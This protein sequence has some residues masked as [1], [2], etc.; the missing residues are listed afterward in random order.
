[1]LKLGV[2]RDTL[3][4]LLLVI[5]IYLQ[6]IRFIVI[7]DTCLVMH[8]TFRSSNEHRIHCRTCRGMSGC[9]QLSPC[10]WTRPDLLYG[11]LWQHLCCSGT[12]QHYFRR[13]TYTV[14]MITMLLHHIFYIK[15]CTNPQNNFQIFKM[16]LYN[17]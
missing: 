3:L 16:F 6:Y 15:L 9:F 8:M 10:F 11:L 17:Q 14:L 13:R 1:M 7:K 12:L 4:S 5:T 2:K